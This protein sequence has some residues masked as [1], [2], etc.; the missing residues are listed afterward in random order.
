SATTTPL[1]GARRCIRA[2]VRES[3]PIGAKISTVR[4]VSAEFG[5][6]ARRSLWCG[7]GFAGEG[8]G[9]GEKKFSRQGIRASAGSAERVSRPSRKWER[10]REEVVIW[11]H[12]VMQDWFVKS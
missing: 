6:I 7:N 8:G 4:I 3:P 12:G 11:R 5:G 9:G 10:S 2:S 1:S